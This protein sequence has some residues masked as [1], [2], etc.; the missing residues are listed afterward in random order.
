MIRKL[1]H[2]LL[3]MADRDYPLILNGD[4]LEV[5]MREDGDCRV[6][7][8]TSARSFYRKWANKIGP[9]VP[10]T[11]DRTSWIGVVHPDGAVLIPINQDA[12]LK[13]N[14]IP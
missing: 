9:Q 7:G 13:R 1:F 3:G 4:L 10:E 5:C 11:F 2:K 6:I 12:N 8:V 14:E